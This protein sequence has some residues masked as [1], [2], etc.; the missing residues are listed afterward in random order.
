[1]TPHEFE[2]TIGTDG[3]VRV[4]MHGVKG[5]QC[6]AYASWLSRVLG[7][8]ASREFTHERYEPEPQVRVDIQ[9]STEA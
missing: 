1:M 7:P 4:H 6:E 9:G 2:I 3:K 8:I 5:S